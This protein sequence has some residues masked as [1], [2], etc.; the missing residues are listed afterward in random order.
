ME[1]LAP[2]AV[3]ADGMHSGN[4]A[5]L[6]AKAVGWVEPETA[7]PAS[8]EEMG[9]VEPVLAAQFLSEK[10]ALLPSVMASP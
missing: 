1:D 6:A 3:V 9:A 5:A 4:R 7:E 10:G 2:V 8:K